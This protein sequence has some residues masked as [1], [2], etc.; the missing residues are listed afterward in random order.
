M[1]APPRVVLRGELY[2]M[3]RARA[4]GSSASHGRPPR[5]RA[6]A[7]ARRC[8]GSGRRVIP[9]RTADGAFRP[10]IS[11]R[12]VRGSRASG[13]VLTLATTVLAAGCGAARQDAHEP[14]G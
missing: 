11:W 10:L 5:T 9:M 1:P 13:V 4:T 8:G 12:R 3:R 2:V 6:P 7:L 14:K